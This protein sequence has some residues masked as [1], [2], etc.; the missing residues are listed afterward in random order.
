MHT[1]TAISLHPQRS[2]DFSQLQPQKCTM[3]PGAEVTHLCQVK[4]RRQ[5]GNMTQ[6]H[7]PVLLWSWS[8]CC[9]A[10]LEDML[11]GFMGFEGKYIK[12]NRARSS[13]SG[14][15]FVLHGKLDHAVHELVIRMLPIW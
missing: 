10:V 12:A 11:W 4:A 1:F 9:G 8:H 2:S 3:S 6:Y 14:L 15:S 7:R 13:K 5:C